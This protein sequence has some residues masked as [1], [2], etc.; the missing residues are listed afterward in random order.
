MHSDASE[1]ASSQ[2]VAASDPR[3]HENCLKTFFQ[4]VFWYFGSTLH[5]PPSPP[6]LHMQYIYIGVCVYIRYIYVYS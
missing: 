3:W 1:T 2:E 5:D 6:A 4:L